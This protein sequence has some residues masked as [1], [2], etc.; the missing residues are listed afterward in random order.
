M[1]KTENYNLQYADKNISIELQYGFRKRL[2][3]TVY[4]DRRVIARI[5]YGLPKRKVEAYLQKKSEWMIKHLDHFEQHPPESDKH[6]SEDEEFAYLGQK[7]KLKLFTGSTHVKLDGNQLIIRVKNP[8]DTDMIVRSLD[9]W[10]RKKAI[11]VLAPRYHDV[12]EQLQ[13]LDLPVTTLRFYKM[14]RRWGSCSI[15]H[16]IT[17]NTELVKKDINLIDYVIIHEICHLKVPAHNKAF[18]SLLASILPDWK[19]RRETLNKNTAL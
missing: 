13:Y 19:K 4:P 11:E 16:V 14:R 12:L 8:K 1:K 18:Y 10:Y 5:P 15:K 6:Y 3:L 9:R 7:Y 2:T 17:L